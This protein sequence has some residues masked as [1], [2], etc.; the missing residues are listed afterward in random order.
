MDEKKILLER[1]TKQIGS[2]AR[3]SV[4]AWHDSDL[5]RVV[6]LKVQGGMNDS[7]LYESLKK[8]IE[9]PEERLAETI[10][11]LTSEAIVRSGF[12][13]WDEER[14]YLRVT[15]EPG[16]NEGFVR[17]DQLFGDRSLIK[18]TGLDSAKT[19]LAMQALAEDMT[20]RYHK[21]FRMPVDKLNTI[22]THIHARIED[23]RRDEA[24]LFQNMMG[25]P[26]EYNS[27]LPTFA[28]QID[29]T[30]NE[31]YGRTDFSVTGNFANVQDAFRVGF[32]Q[33]YGS[34]NAR[35]TY[36]IHNQPSLQL[37]CYL[38]VKRDDHVYNLELGAGLHN[39]AISGSFEFFTETKEK[40]KQL[41]ERLELVLD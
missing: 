14:K 3:D 28:G 37:G 1:A 2:N 24:R 36:V 5:A 27:D 33:S 26:A 38:T 13:G 34:A 30:H 10:K 16:I 23:L 22:R 40:G 25:L 6:L 4:Q 8:S 15:L 29:P 21:E 17:T 20:F 35:K 9:V 12:E 31:G 41:Q 18:R 39:A 11:Y 32:D 19:M 7:I